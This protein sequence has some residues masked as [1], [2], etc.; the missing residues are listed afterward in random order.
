MGSTAEVKNSFS[1]IRGLIT[2]ASSLTFPEDASI[3]EENY[4]LD[5]DGSRRK[6]LGIDYE[7][8][9]SLNT[10]PSIIDY[11]VSSVDTFL[12]DTVDENGN[13]TFLVVQIGNIIYFHN[14]SVPGQSISGSA[15][16]F[17]I[18]LNN[19]LA[20]NSSNAA[21][22]SV[23]FSSGK[24]LLF[25]NSEAI[26]PLYVIYNQS[27]NS[28]TVVDYEVLIRDFDGLDDG[29]AVDER[30]V[31]LTA[32]H[33]YNLRNQGWPQSTKIS[34]TKDGTSTALFD[35]LPFTKGQLNVYPSNADI[36]YLAKLTSA[37]EPEAVNAYW[38]EEL[39]SSLVGTTRAP[40]GKFILN[41]FNKIR[42]GKPQFVS[43]TFTETI[44]ERPEA[45]AFYSGRVFLGLKTTVF[46]SQVLTGKEKIGRCYSEA[47]PTAEDINDVVATDGGTLEIP[48]AGIIKQ[49]IPL[50]GKI[51]VLAT[52]GIWQIDGQADPFSA[53]NN[54]ALRLSTVGVNNNKSG[55]LVDNSVIFTSPSGIYSITAQEVSSELVV[56]SITE[57][58]IQSYYLSNI[59]SANN[60]VRGQY[61][62]TSKRV[63]WIWNNDSAVAKYYDILILDVILGSFYKYR[64]AR[65]DEDSPFIAGLFTT[66]EFST[67]T[68]TLNLVDSLGN[69]IIDSLGNTL[70]N[71]SSRIASSPSGFKFLTIARN[72]EIPTDYAYTFSELTNENLIDWYS[73]DNTGVDYE[74]FLL[75]GYELNDDQMRYKQA[76]IIQTSFNRTETAY[77]DNGSGGLEFDFPSS[78]L[79]STYW[80]WAVDSVSGKIT[81]EQEVYRFKRFYLPGI[82]GENFSSGLKVV[83][84]RTKLRG[85][86]KAVHLRFRTPPR[87]HTQ[88]LGWSILY[89]GNDTP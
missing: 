84:S 58:T 74:A 71:S 60:T 11:D 5:K 28:I 37:K 23:S 57:N 85:R 75:T 36:I 3:D 39:L 72:S 25:I 56:S 9:F 44:N 40:R 61:D 70:I 41:A 88:L 18:N 54:R 65:G 4:L 16:P 30:P 38:P 68:E 20:P 46:Y 45:V 51:V 26:N 29:L 64:F 81:N 31:D 42:V 89:R 22:N 52:N 79:L 10:G 12:W 87:K 49:F 50:G 69:R 66:Q 43:V 13:L 8:S 83:S 1:F 47:D 7:E 67:E 33:E 34:N 86:G 15:L 17:T 73:Y 63:F 2:E 24:G 53:I 32:E 35:P 27:L 76:P 82:I 62:N 21:I 6:R 77:I 48:D 19:Y 78:C 14:A 55:V 59:A 80:N